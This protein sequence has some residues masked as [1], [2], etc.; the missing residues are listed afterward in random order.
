MTTSERRRAPRAPERIS[1]AVIDGGRE[2]RTETKNL[3]AVGAYCTLDRFIPPMSKLQLDFELPHG[4][5]RVR[6]RCAGVVVRVEPV[7]ANAQRM[8][9]NVALFFTELSERHR[10]AISRFVRQRLAQSPPTI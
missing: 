9:Y 3:S 2:F 7:V 5:R 8:Q 1:L 10:S 4:S 6:V